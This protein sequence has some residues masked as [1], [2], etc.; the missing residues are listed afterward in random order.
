MKLQWWHL[1][2]K[3]I[4]PNSGLLTKY[5]S[6]RLSLVPVMNND[7]WIISTNHCL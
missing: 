3:F 7:A 2:I 5:G 1:Q 6:N 4:K